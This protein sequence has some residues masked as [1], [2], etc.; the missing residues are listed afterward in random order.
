M[1]LG[2]LL[3]PFAGDGVAWR[4]VVENRLVK[5]VPEEKDRREFGPRHG[6]GG[7]GFTGPG[8]SRGTK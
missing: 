7:G 8:W 6:M 2:G 1:E 3:F 5:I 4:E